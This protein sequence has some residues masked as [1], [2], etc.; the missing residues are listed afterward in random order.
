MSLG[1]ELPAGSQSAEAQALQIAVPT[2]SAFES[3]DGCLG[4]SL[5]QEAQPGL[6]H[7]F[8][9]GRAAATH[10]L[11]HQSVVDVDARFHVS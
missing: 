3:A 9:A 8:L 7:S 5:D 1:S 10:S 6:D 2:Y 4:M 11:A